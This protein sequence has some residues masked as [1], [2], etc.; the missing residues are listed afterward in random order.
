MHQWKLDKHTIFACAYDDE[1]IKSS[2]LKE[3]A[4][5]MVAGAMTRSISIRSNTTYPQ[6]MAKLQKK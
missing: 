2:A 1:D 5:E 3:L 4:N 6:A